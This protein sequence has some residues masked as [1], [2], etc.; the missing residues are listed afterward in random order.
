PSRVTRT[1]RRAA[2]ALREAHSSKTGRNAAR[3]RGVTAR[4]L[5]GRDVAAASSPGVPGVRLS[6]D[7][8]SGP[9]YHC[10]TAGILFLT[11]DVYVCANASRNS[12]TA[13]DGASV[14]RFALGRPVTDA[15]RRRGDPE[16]QRHDAAVVDAWLVPPD[17]PRQ[18]VADKRR[19]AMRLSAL[20]KEFC[21][22]LQVEKEAAPRSITTYGWCFGDFEDFARKH[23]GG[24]VLI[25]HF[26]PE[27]CRDYQ[28]ELSARGLATSTIRLRLATLGSFGK[29][30]VRRE[31]LAK[32]PLDFLTRPQRKERVPRVP[33]W[34]T[35]GRIVEQAAD[36]RE[37]AILA[38]L[39]YGGLR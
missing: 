35:I 32:N 26:T 16:H 22:Y 3:S 36:R 34:T 27:L 39:A 5:D 24:A 9:I 23:M 1:A 29:W 38:L 17:N 11:V 10:V 28:Y 8:D 2:S 30:A 19:Q 12:E 21:Q 13:G 6:G 18:R 7:C 4:P 25:S 15:P 20:F 31:R 33:R 37:R 14:S